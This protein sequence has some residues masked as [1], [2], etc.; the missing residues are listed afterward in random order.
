MG[1]ELKTEHREKQSSTHWRDKL[2]LHY[3]GPKRQN[4]R[5]MQVFMEPQVREDIKAL[6]RTE[7]MGAQEFVERLITKAVSENQP[8]VKEG[9]KLLQESDKKFYRTGMKHLEE[10]NDRLKKALEAATT[11]RRHR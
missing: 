1:K 11:P 8:R 7:E 6:A 2:P 4:K 5:A 3:V 10:E 9:R